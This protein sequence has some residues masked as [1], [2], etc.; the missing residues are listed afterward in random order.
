MEIIFHQ[1]SRGELTQ[2]WCY[3]WMRTIPG[4]EDFAQEDD[5]KEAKRAYEYMGF[6][7]ISVLKILRLSMCLLAHV[8]TQE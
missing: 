6:T 3:L 8:R 4:P 2:E 5:Q 1:W 7:R